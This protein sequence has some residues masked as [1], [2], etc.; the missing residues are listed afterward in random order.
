MKVCYEGH[1]IEGKCD[2]AEICNP[3]NN[4]SS[5]IKDPKGNQICA[6]CKKDYVAKIDLNFMPP[7][8]FCEKKEKQELNGCF[9]GVEDFCLFCDYQ[10]YVNTDGKC[11]L[12]L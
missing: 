6:A 9:M 10:Y 2:S 8:I 5:C 4:C 1:I 11:S 3:E 12:N 7:Q